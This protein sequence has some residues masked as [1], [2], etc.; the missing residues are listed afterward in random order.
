MYITWLLGWRGGDSRHLQRGQGGVRLLRPP[1][2]QAQDSRVLH[3]AL[4][5]KV[6]LYHTLLLST[7]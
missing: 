1:V 5:E 6:Y 3:T 4:S 7:L 2:G